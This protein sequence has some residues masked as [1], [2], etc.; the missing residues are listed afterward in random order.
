MSS[1]NAVAVRY[2]QE[3]PAA[4]GVTPTVGAWETAR[5][6]S[7][8]IGGSPNTTISNESRDDRMDADQ[9]QVG[10][11]V[12]GNI[13][14]ELSAVTW[15]AFMEAAMCGDWD[16]GVA[17]ELNIGTQNR[18]FS[19]EK[20]FTD[21]D[22]PYFISTTGMRVG[23]MS[24]SFAYGQISTVDFGF[25]GNGVTTG[26]VSAVAGSATVNPATLNPVMNASSNVTN[27]LVNG[28][29]AD[30]CIQQ[31]DLNLDNNMTEVTCIG[32][33]APADQTKFGASVTGSLTPY[34]DDSTQAIY[35]A[36]VNN[37]SFTLEFTA[38]DGVNERTFLIPN[39]RVS[40]DAPNKGGKDQDVFIPFDFTGLFDPVTNTSMRI[41]RS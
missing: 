31:I 5:A 39:A 35:D 15:D 25:A 17:D 32:D 33:L 11:D 19:I 29:P 23:S 20:E 9:V 14:G 1:S 21:H 27:I 30:Q 4:Y 7:E 6:V 34:F 10:L 40:G 24:L 38:S 22:T 8:S 26:N 2:I 12:S 36:I 37:T 41:T 3:D 28:L 18:S 13:S 16:E